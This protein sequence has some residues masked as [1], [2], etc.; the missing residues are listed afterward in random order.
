MRAHLAVAGRFVGVGVGIGLV[1]AL[2][3][4]PVAE[5]KEA[6]G[7]ASCMGIERSA[8]SP[9]GSSDEVP[10]GSAAFTAEVKAIADAFGVSPGAI[11]AV[12]AHLHEGSHDACDEA[13]E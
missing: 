7:S 13:L 8:I 3:W 2:A 5:A 1:A 4:A 12:V 10:G 6:S 9:P 11:F